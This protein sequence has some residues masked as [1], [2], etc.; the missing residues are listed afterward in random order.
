MRY[1][2]ESPH[3]KRQGSPAA[4]VLSITAFDTGKSSV[5]ATVR[6]APPG[7]R[8]S[9]QLAAEVLALRPTLARHTCKQRGF[10]LF[11]DK[12]VGTTLPHLVE[13][14]AID[15]L[16]ERMQ[17]GG[18]TGTT[19]TTGTPGTA[20]TAS[21]PSTISAANTPNSD[22][23]SRDTPRAAQ[24]VAG[25]TTWLDQQQGLMRVRVSCTANTAEATR[26]TRAALCDAV[27]LLNALI[28]QQY[29]IFE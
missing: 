17:G 4:A 19:G 21:T 7:L 12:L 2:T 9:P 28:E 5:H 6:V 24:P 26:A 22:S 14:L 27:T 15:L 25:T 8:V 16:V 10:G 13:H 20:G 1:S 29:G 11:A 3:K 18:T 23:G